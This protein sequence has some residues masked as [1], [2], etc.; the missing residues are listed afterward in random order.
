MK[1]VVCEFITHMQPQLQAG[2]GTAA[3]TAA[4]AG[5]RG[6]GQKPAD[7]QLCVWKHMNLET[8]SRHSTQLPFCSISG[9]FQRACVLWC[10]LNSLG[11]GN[12]WLHPSPQHFTMLFYCCVWPLAKLQKLSDG[13][14]GINLCCTLGKINLWWGMDEAPRYTWLQKTSAQG[15]LCDCA[16]ALREQPAHD[17][18]FCCLGLER[19]AHNSVHPCPWNSHIILKHRQRSIGAM[20]LEVLPRFCV[21]QPGEGP[22]HGLPHQPIS[23]P[24]CCSHTVHSDLLQNLMQLSMIPLKS[25]NQTSSKT[26]EQVAQRGVDVP[27]LE[28]FKDM[29]DRAPSNLF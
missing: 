11:R 8:P 26:L 23:L 16:A 24:C 3:R 18:T 28:I 22:E 9:T 7:A 1:L 29:L 6:V 19:A 4:G 13:E 25:M 27:F 14:R 2:A 12:P 15:N 17:N 5:S 10:T 21:Q 20:L